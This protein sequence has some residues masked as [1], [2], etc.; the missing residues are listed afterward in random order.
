MLVGERDQANM[1]ELIRPTSFKGNG[2]SCIIDKT[3]SLIIA[4]TDKRP[5]N[6]LQEVMGGAQKQGA[7]N[8]VKQDIENNKSGVIHFKATTGESVIMAYQMMGISDWVMLR[9]V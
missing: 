2:L 1:Q 7:I 4:P 3:G 8:K 5:F 6:E 9:C